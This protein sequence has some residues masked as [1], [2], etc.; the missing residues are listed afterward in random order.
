MCQRNGHIFAST[1]YWSILG[2]SRYVLVYCRRSARFSSNFFQ[3]KHSCSYIAASDSS[4]RYRGQFLFGND[5][6]LGSFVFCDELKKEADIALEFYVAVV[7][8]AYNDAMGKVCL[9]TPRP[10]HTACIPSFL[11]SN[12]CNE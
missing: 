8:I 4:G 11:H 5:N 9:Y 2:A 6:W 3:H 7:T 1:G 12:E 10:L